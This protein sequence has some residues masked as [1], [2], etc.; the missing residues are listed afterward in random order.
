MAEGP[1]C[2]MGR[3]VAVA[4]TSHRFVR[5]SEADRLPPVCSAVIS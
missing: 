4:M 5:N 1:V 2:P 3:L